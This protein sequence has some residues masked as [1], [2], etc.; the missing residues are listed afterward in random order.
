MRSRE[1]CDEAYGASSKRRLGH[2]TLQ[3]E[4]NGFI[5]RVLGSQR[6]RHGKSSDLSTWLAG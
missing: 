3:P 2:R 5:L 6:A 1:V 4:L